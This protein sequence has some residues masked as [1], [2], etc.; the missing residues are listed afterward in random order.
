V[1]PIVDFTQ[2]D[3]DGDGFV[4]GVFIVHSGQGFEWS[5]SPDDIWSHMWNTAVPPEVDGVT[6]TEYCCQPEY[7]NI[8][9]DQAIGVYTHE[10]MHLVFGIPDLYDYDGSSGGLGMWSLMAGE[11]FVS[12]A[13]RLA[14]TICK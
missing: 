3:N 2:Y 6:V 10:G 14:G 12:P 11:I 9:G 13:F 4:E 1:D 5:G 7:L 8:P